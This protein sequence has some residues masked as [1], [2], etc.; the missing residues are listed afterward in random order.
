VVVGNV[1]GAM[2]NARACGV[3]IVILGLIGLSRAEWA[4]WTN[5]GVGVWLLVSPWILDY[6]AIG[7]LTWNA[8]VIGI[9]VAVLAGYRASSLRR[10]RPIM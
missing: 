3:L 10:V 5:V 7:S 9:V 6:S 4:E 2:W 1:D 8:V